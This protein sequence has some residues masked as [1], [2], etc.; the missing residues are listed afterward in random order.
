[1]WWNRWTSFPPSERSVTDEESADSSHALTRK[2]IHYIH[3]IH[4]SVGKR[5]R[6]AM[7]VVGPFSTL[8]PG[9]PCGAPDHPQRLPYAAATTK[10]VRLP[11]ILRWFVIIT[12][13]AHV[14]LR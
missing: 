4:H 12:T 14:N 2:H 8:S 13:R 5:P 11:A 9:E 3:L 1:M 10:Q 6:R 7:E